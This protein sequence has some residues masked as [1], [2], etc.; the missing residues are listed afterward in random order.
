MI[1]RPIPRCL[2]HPDLHWPAQENND[3]EKDMHPYPRYFALISFFGMDLN[4]RKDG[5]KHDLL[6]YFIYSMSCNLP[7]LAWH[8]PFPTNPERL[9]WQW[10]V[11]ICSITP[12]I[13][14]LVAIL[15]RTKIPKPAVILACS[16][17]LLISLSG[18]LAR[19]YMLKSFFLYHDFQ[20]SASFKHEEL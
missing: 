19:V 16:F 11:V 15:S 9:M 17:V 7:F 3:I 6:D 13:S 20:P 1:C 8:F 14:S 5:W 12:V 2:F 4:M 18:F 10:A